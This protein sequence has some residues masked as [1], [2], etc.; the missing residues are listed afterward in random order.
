MA[1]SAKNA[2]AAQ[3][4]A[5]DAPAPRMRGRMMTLG[6]VGGVMIL[7][8]IGL[9]VV[10]KMF[11]AEPDPTEGMTLQSTTRAWEQSAEL[12]LVEIKALNS[13]GGRA[14]YYRLKVGLVVHTADLEKVR[15]II[16]R[17][18]LTIEDLIGRAIRE[19]DERELTEP[20]LETIKRRLRLELGAL[21]G[22]EKLI[23]G[24]LIP[25]CMPLPT[26]I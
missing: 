23:E 21:L 16:E 3:V 24:V 13:N 8:G 26:G 11:G 7:E 9:F 4:A 19:A 17:K 18:K 15:P 6:L 25:E 14:V 10:F 22:D 5:K 2:E 12:P 20:N 1:E